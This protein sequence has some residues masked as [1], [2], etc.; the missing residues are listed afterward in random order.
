V[1]L[2][3]EL[4]RTVPDDVAAVVVPVVA[5]QAPDGVDA[6]FLA[7]QGFEGKK[8]EVRCL[9]GADGRPVYVV[10]LGPEA[11]VDAAV[12][13]SVAGSLAR[14]A[15]REASLAIPLAAREQIDAAASAQAVVE[16]L[17]L[18]GYQYDDFKSQA[19]PRALSRVVL[20]GSAGKRVQ[21]AV[22][23]AQVIAGAVTMARDLVN[24]P[25]GSLTPDK[26]AKRAVAEGAAAGFDLEVW[27]EKRIRAERLGGLLGVNRGSALPP[28]LLALRYEPDRPKGTVALVGKGI[29]FD[30]GGLSIKTGDGMIGMKGDM[31]GGAAVLG[32]FRV[33][34]SLGL[35]VRL[36]GFV[37][38]TDNMTGGDATR[39]GDV[40]TIRNGKTVEVLN[41][42][43][44]GRLILAD[45]LSLASEATP[46]AI[47]D[48][49][50]LTGACMVA[51]GERT[52][53]LMGNHRGWVDQIRRAAD[54]A[55]EPVWPLPLPA[56]LRPKLDSEIADLRNIS[57]G[58]YGG[59]LTAG[60]FL[61]EFV[62]DGI[63]WAHLDIAGPS[64]SAEVD[65]E[66][67]KGGTGF[68]IRTLV[69]LLA[70]FSKP[71]RSEV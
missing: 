5:G 15:R 63:P 44:E 67:V 48:L 50:T 49:A 35:K 25:G 37:P 4:A 14:A 59:T 11:D 1:P 64:D 10:G 17:A 28:R 47:I 38:L 71:R 32:A 36:L 60:L 18:G 46:D 23:K 7:A 43:A 54:G 61:R 40:L 58:R 8:G 51:L 2:S 9:P 19:T 20:V 31:G 57:T 65:G 33:A 30:S 24:E 16:G 12:L 34:A 53:G 42:D 22:D 39:V 70:S 68:G 56:H 29:T 69:D 26:L 3:I 62:A 45:G 6:A 66:I 52:A 13:R 55:G 41:T 27:D 21:D